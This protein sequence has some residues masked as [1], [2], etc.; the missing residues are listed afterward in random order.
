MLVENTGSCRQTV[1]LNR[2]SDV[3]LLPRFGYRTVKDRVERPQGSKSLQEATL[4]VL[5][6]LS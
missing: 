1:I 6:P 3:S 5:D 4:V 2:G